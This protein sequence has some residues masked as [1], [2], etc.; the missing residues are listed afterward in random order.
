[1][2]RKNMVKKYNPNDADTGKRRLLKGAALGAGAVVLAPAEW[3]TPVFRGVVSP[4]HADIVSAAAGTYTV[5]HPDDP[6]G[7]GGR[8]AT[9]EWDGGIINRKVRIKYNGVRI[10]FYIV[11]IDK[12]NQSY[13]TLRNPDPLPP[14]GYNF[15]ALKIK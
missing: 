1:M 11:R 8:R 13:I 7:S 14:A 6:F 10:G 9:F 2:Q 12:S 3:S 5:D 4:A 15:F